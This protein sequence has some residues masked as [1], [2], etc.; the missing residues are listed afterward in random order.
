[1]AIMDGPGVKR[2]ILRT[3]IAL[4]AMATVVAA[5]G[6]AWAQGWTES[7]G[8]WTLND[9]QNN[10]QN[11][12]FGGVAGHDVT[13]DVTITNTGHWTLGSPGT[14]VF[15]PAAIVFTNDSVF[16]IDGDADDRGKLTLYSKTTG[17]NHTFGSLFR[18]TNTSPHLIN[19]QVN[20]IQSVHNL[21][22]TFGLA[23]E[24]SSV[25]LTLRLDQFG[26]VNVTV[27]VGSTAYGVFAYSNV[28]FDGDLA[29]DISAT[30]D[31]DFAYG[32]RSY[33]ADVTIDGNLTGNII[34]RA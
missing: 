12:P 32:V 23:S 30:A 22:A 19:G 26:D 2:I 11:N 25:Q 27:D 10:T 21:N 34:A 16:T 20:V 6:S 9:T 3:L 15:L 7:G 18:S 14:P 4:V 24:Y 31:T 29:G 5:A 1:M 28:T 17:F 33:N 8:N 13:G